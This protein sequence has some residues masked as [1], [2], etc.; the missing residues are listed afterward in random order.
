[1]TIVKAVA[2]GPILFTASNGDQLSIP[3]SVLRFNDATG[4]LVTPD[5]PFVVAKD[6][7][8]HLVATGFIQPEPPRATPAPSTTPVMTLTAAS[9]GE[10]GNNITAIINYD[11]VTPPTDPTYTIAVSASIALD[12]TMSTVANILGTDANLPTRATP[13]FIVASSLNTSRKPKNMAP[14][15]LASGSYQIK[16]AADATAFTIQARKTP[17]MGTT[18]TVS[19]TNANETL[20]SFTLT[21]AWSATLTSVGIDVPTDLTARRASFATAFGY[22]IDVVYNGGKPKAGT[23]ILTGGTDGTKAHFSTQAVL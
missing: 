12:L 21:L 14:T 19:I 16:D 15:A 22:L 7:L 6:W 3:A 13:A 8:D 17:P 1:M 18:V 23:F 5:A 9:A 10:W 20:G 4:K 2:S 11:T